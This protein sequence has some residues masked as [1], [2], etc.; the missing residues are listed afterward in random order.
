MKPSY[1]DEL[2]LLASSYAWASHADIEG[3]SDLLIWYLQ[4][5]D[6]NNQLWIGVP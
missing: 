3:V 6:E 4:L 5:E 1:M 2:G